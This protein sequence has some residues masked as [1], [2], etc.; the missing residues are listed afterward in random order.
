ML[1]GVLSEIG[2]F[3]FIEIDTYQLAEARF[4]VHD[5]GIAVLGDGVATTAAA[6]PQIL[7]VRSLSINITAL[8]VELCEL[9]EVPVHAP[10]NGGEG[11]HEAAD[12]FPLETWPPSPRCV[13]ARSPSND[14][15]DGQTASA[16]IGT[17]HDTASIDGES[18]TAIDGLVAVAVAADYDSNAIGDTLCDLDTAKLGQTATTH[19]PLHDRWPTHSAV[20]SN[21]E[22]DSIQSPSFTIS[23]SIGSF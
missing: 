17:L 8:A 13:G 5:A 23:N 9:L 4:G 12:R 2:L 11:S 19:Y 16:A 10:I 7:K 22:S 20:G 15:D 6:S 18:T 14:C 3:G 1:A 21:N